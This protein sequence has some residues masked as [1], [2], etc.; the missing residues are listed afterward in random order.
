MEEKEISSH[1]GHKLV[2]IWGINYYAWFKSDSLLILNIF[3]KSLTLILLVF[4]VF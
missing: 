1:L 3:N 2:L 4:I